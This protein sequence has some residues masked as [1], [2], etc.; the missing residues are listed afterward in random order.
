MDKLGDDFVTL[1]GDVVDTVRDAR[2]TG[3]DIAKDMAERARTGY[4][5]VCEYVSERPLASVLIAAGVGA[6]LARI[7]LPRH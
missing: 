6:I 3:I 2:T 1:K 7:L 4:G 5:Q